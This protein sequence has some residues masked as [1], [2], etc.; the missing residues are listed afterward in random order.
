MP[1]MKLDFS[2]EDLVGSPVQIS[3]GAWVFGALHYP[4]LSS[5]NMRV[6]RPSHLLLLSVSVN[7][8]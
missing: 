7:M 1:K 4:G 5:K 2:K 3:D 6:S 8:C